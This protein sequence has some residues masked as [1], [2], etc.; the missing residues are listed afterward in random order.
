[1]EDER[2]EILMDFRSVCILSDHLIECRGWKELEI[3]PTHIATVHVPSTTEVISSSSAAVVVPSSST[4][5]VI[6][7]VAITVPILIRVFPPLVACSDHKGD[8]VSFQRHW[9]L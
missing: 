2:R 6:I 3:A 9:R 7:S 8:L 5:V 4:V 1:M